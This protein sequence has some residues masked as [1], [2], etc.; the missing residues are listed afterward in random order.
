MPLD[1]PENWQEATSIYEFS[2]ND[3]HGNPVDLDKYKGNVCIIVNVASRCGHTKSNYEQFVELYEKYGEEKGLKILAFPCNQ[4]GKQEPGNS[5]TI[6]KFAEK[7]NVKFDMFEK[8][9]VNGP[10]AHPL[11]NYLKNKIPGPNGKPIKW[12]FTKFIINQDGEPVERFTPATKP[13]T[14]VKTLEKYW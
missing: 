9:N 14:L 2:A 10:D 11:W 1:N 5:E 7:K 8:V 3:I 12:N 4:F 6:C 13:I